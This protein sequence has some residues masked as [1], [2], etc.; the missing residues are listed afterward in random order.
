[1]MRAIA[2]AI[3]G[4]LGIGT[5]LAQAHEGQP[6]GGGP[7]GGNQGGS[8]GRVPSYGYFGNG[9]HDTVPHW[10][11]TTTP[12]GRFSWYGTGR[13][14]YQP[15][16]HRVTPYSYESYSSGPFGRTRSFH[17]PKPYRYMPW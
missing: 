8:Y 3:V 4:L 9:G 17:S 14:D 1:M 6:H 15:H 5:T 12:F 2:F 7:P 16:E 11:E 10:H 13:H